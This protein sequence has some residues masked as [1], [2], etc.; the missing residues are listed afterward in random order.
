M[1]PQ[2]GSR[3]Y[4]D[5]ILFSFHYQLIT[6]LLIIW[7]ISTTGEFRKTTAIH[8]K[9]LSTFARGLSLTVWTSFQIAAIVLILRRKSSLGLRV[10]KIIKTASA[11]TLHCFVHYFIGMAVWHSILQNVANFGGSNAFVLGQVFCGQTTN[12]WLT[13][14]VLFIV[15]GRNSWTHYDWT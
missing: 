9:T 11:K 7:F 3:Y 1:F 13:G 4:F 14:L 8:R 5:T 6:S 10:V 15:L 12:C 2:G